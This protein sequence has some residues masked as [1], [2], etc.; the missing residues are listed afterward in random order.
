MKGLGLEVKTLEKSLYLNYPLGT[1]VSVD[2]IGRD[3]ELKILRIRLTVDLKVIYM[4][5][6]DVI[7]SM[8]WLTAHRVVIDYDSRRI[9]TYTRDNIQ[10]T[11]QG[12]KA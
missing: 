3:C 10:V 12:E 5:E 4:S 6:F 9:T 7:L 2:Q 8:D 1:R 11:F